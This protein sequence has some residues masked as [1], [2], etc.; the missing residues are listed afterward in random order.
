M[1]AAPEAILITAAG[2]ALAALAWW[3]GRRGL[4]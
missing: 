2:L 1:M 3:L 4:R